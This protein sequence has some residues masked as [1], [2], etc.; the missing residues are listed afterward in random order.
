MS[1]P[2]RRSSGRGC[3]CTLRCRRALPGVQHAMQ[4]R[5]RVFDV[6]V[7]VL[8]GAAFCREHATAVDLAEIP[9]GKFVMPL[10]LLGFFVIVSQ[11][12]PAVFGKAAEANEF[13]FLLGSRPVLAPCIPLVQCDPSF[14]DKLL[15][16]IKCP[17]V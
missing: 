9:I 6:V 5:D 13:I 1:G 17:A 11:I 8:A 15:G 2:A 7:L 12:P 10:G 14:V 4:V 16:M 3:A